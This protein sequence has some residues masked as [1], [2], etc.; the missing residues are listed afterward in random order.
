VTG[1]LLFLT[2]PVGLVFVLCLGSRHF[3]KHH[4]APLAKAIAGALFPVLIAVAALAALM[5]IVRVAGQWIPTEWIYSEE[6]ALK[7]V[8]GWLKDNPQSYVFTFPKALIVASVLFLMA[9]FSPSLITLERSA[10]QASKLAGIG[11]GVLVFMASFT[12]IGD[13]SVGTY[14]DGSAL[15]EAGREY[16]LSF[17]AQTKYEGRAVAAAV[18]TESIQSSYGSAPTQDDRDLTDSLA[19]LFKT[20]REHCR[21]SDTSGC[22]F[23]RAGGNRGEPTIQVELPIELR[24]HPASSQD[25]ESS[26][27][28]VDLQ[29][30][31]DK[32]AR[33]LA[34]KGE[35]QLVD[36]M[37][38]FAEKRTGADSSPLLSHDAATDGFIRSLVS[39]LLD[40]VGPAVYERIKPHVQRAEVVK[41]FWEEVQERQRAIRDALTKRDKPPSVSLSD[42]RLTPNQALERVR[43]RLPNERLQERVTESARPF[44]RGVK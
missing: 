6:T 29:K 10:R 18:L 14:V 3:C 36:A 5:G 17:R 16:K 31:L 8:Q 35:G 30:E 27:D 19:A 37:W 26:L 28:R 4:K 34:K 33:E 1:L 2:S 39:D 43:D 22:S 7:S 41:K 44:R 13:P 11:A 32:D 12:F 21:L 15:S 23:S 24:F 20:A 9:H 38:A 42:V 40:S 25:W